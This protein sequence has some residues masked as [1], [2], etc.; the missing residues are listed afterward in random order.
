MKKILTSISAIWCSVFFC[1]ALM[2]QG[3]YPTSWE[4]VI[5]EEKGDTVVV[6]GYYETNLFNTLL[7]AV[8][9]D[10]N[11][12]GSRANPNRIYETIPGEYYI[13]L[14]SERLDEIYRL[15]TASLSEATL[16]NIGFA[17]AEELI[18]LLSSFLKYQTDTRELKSLKFLEKLKNTSL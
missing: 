14:S 18:I 2:A 13:R 17:S 12:D 6:K 4:S 15:Q 10:T 1:T 16:F 5:K 8:K 9:A 11:A 7:W 3:L